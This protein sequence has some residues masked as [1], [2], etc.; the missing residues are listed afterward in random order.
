MVVAVVVH[1][2]DVVCSLQCALKLA[3]YKDLLC[4]RMYFVRARLDEGKIEQ[5][6]E[7]LQS[8][9]CEGAYLVITPPS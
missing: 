6:R 2:V 9:V 1:L 7:C 4:A 8:R 3:N 5:S